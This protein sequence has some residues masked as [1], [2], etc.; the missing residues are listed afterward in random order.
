MIGKATHTFG[1]D[2]LNTIRVGWWVQKYTWLPLDQ[3][4]HDVLVFATT[5]PSADFAPGEVELVR[6]PAGDLVKFVDWTATP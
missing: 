5:A 1:P 3:F 2:G 4:E 6:V